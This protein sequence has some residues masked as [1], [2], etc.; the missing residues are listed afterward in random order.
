MFLMQASSQNTNALSIG[1]KVPEIRFERAINYS[2][3]EFKLSDFKGKLVI[4]DFFG[5]WC[6]SCI[7]GIPRLDSLQKLF[8]D[9]LQ[10][11]VLCQDVS[12]DHVRKFIEHKWGNQQLKLPFVLADSSYINLFPHR[13]IPHEVWITPDGKVSAI[14]SDEPITEQ[15]IRSVLNNRSVQLPTK[16]D[17][18]NFHDDEPLIFEGNGGSEHD[19]VFN[20]LLTHFLNGVPAKVGIWEDSLNHTKRYHAINRSIPT[21]YEL[22][23]HLGPERLILETRDSIKFFFNPNSSLTNEEWYK[24][25][26][27]SYELTM[28]DTTSA[29]TIQK[30]MLNDLNRYLGINGRIEK[31]E[32][33]YW[34]LVRIYSNTYYTQNKFAKPKP[35][36]GKTFVWRNKS[37]SSLAKVLQS[38]LTPIILDDTGITTL[39]SVVLHH[40]A[41][42]S[43]TALKNELNNYGLDLILAK[44]KIDMLIITDH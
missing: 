21:L 37:S 30:I 5:T 25:Y 6:G 34:S 12:I 19:I 41:L 17:Q 7:P 4:L 33:T 20:S 38:P 26:A 27:Y 28:P 10:V 9:S 36:Q 43:I 42:K 31:R 39:I 3:D 22:A 16:I 44:K 32:K 15:N 11:I 24:K 35:E 8:K 40:D 1:E 29:A 13:M 23:T 18:L 2:K 14:T